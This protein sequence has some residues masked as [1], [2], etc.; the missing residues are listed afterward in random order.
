MNTRPVLEWVASHQDD[1]HTIDINDL[2]KVTQLNVKADKLATKDSIDY[3]QNQ[4]C[5]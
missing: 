2:S 1:D 5:L 4:G 3:I